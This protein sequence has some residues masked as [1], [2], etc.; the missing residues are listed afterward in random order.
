MD[1]NWRAVFVGF[2]VAVTLGLIVSWLVPPSQTTAVVHAVPGLIGGAVAGY[3]VTGVGDGAIHGGLATV[4]GGLLTLVVLAVFGVLFAGVV[5]TT[6]AVVVG[7][8]VLLG[9]AIPGAIAGAVGGWASGR[10]E[11]RETTATE[12]Q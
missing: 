4:I 3:M 7:L 12:T 8:L 9:Q 6:G 5:V 10:G 2:L 11:A 1:I